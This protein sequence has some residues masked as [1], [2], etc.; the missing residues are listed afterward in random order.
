M[1]NSTIYFWNPVKQ[2][3]ADLVAI[4]KYNPN[5]SI[6]S[7]ADIGVL[8][9]FPLVET[10]PPDYDELNQTLTWTVE[11]KQSP[12]GPQFYRSYKVGQLPP[13]QVQENTLLFIERQKKMFLETAQAKLDSFART[14]GY[15]D[16]KSAVGYA[17]S[18]IPTFRLE[19]EICIRKRD[20]MWSAL[21]AVLARAENKEI[22]IPATFSEI[23]SYLPVLEWK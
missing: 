10:L 23:E 18:S 21:Y 1:T 22:P 20:E 14:K 19:A 12:K 17:G 4:R 5:A 15:D 9:W 3:I 6:P 16:I 8:G 7:G 2:E 11:S 13:E